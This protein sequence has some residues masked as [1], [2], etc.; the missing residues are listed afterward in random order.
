MLLL[1]I[2]PD[3]QVT[4]TY[5]SWEMLRLIISSSMNDQSR[6]PPLGLCF[7]LVSTMHSVSVFVCRSWFELLFT[8]LFPFRI[9]ILGVNCKNWLHPQYAFFFWIIDLCFFLLGD[10]HLEA[11]PRWPA[12]WGM[13]VREADVTWRSQD[14]HRFLHIP[15]GSLSSLNESTNNG[16]FTGCQPKWQ[17]DPTRVAIR[18]FHLVE[19]WIATGNRLNNN[20]FCD[21]G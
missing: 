14:W 20:P 17:Q 3:F 9:K 12:Q 2:I 8:K 4:S 11:W 15:L 13:S 10:V 1:L 18:C 19:T 6:S 21:F 5:E 7:S 16:W